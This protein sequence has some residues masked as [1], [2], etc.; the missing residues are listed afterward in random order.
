VTETRIV[1]ALPL[2]PNVAN[3]RGHWRTR[4]KLRAEF[5]EACD[6]RLLAQ[7]IPAPPDQPWRRVMVSAHLVVGSRMDDDNAMARCKY[8]LDW[9]VR[10]GYLVDDRAANCWWR[11]IPTQTVSRTQPGSVVLTLDPFGVAA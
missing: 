3:S 5:F 6:L 2:P 1:L 11:G 10:T 7:Q 9:A 4:N 8:A